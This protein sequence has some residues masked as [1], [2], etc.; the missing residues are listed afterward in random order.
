MKKT[1]NYEI[2]SSKPIYT[3]YESQKKKKTENLLKGLMTEN[4]RN[5]KKE[6]YFQIQQLQRATNN[7]KPKY[8]H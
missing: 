3:F 8:L 2:P 5:L 4:F 6:L 1:E 7:M